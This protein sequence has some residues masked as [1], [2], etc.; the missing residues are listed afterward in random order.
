MGQPVLWPP[1]PPKALGLIGAGEGQAD[2]RLLSGRSVA[3]ARNDPAWASRRS[4]SDRSRSGALTAHQ[5][6]Q[7]AN[8]RSSTGQP[9]RFDR[10]PPMPRGWVPL[11]RPPR[12]LYSPYGRPSRSTDEPRPDSPTGPRL[13]IGDKYLGSPFPDA[14]TLKYSSP[15]A[16]VEAV[17]DY[18][19]VAS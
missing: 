12:W 16:S 13:P 8:R 18:L 1:R 19:G 6:Q 2:D 4:R 5:R 14:L 17:S 10:T 7:P 3:S 11:P 9:Y 15:R